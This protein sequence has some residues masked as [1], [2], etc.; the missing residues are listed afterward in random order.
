M[1]P[2]Y[3]NPRAQSNVPTAKLPRKINVSRRTI[4]TPETN[5]GFAVGPEAGMVRLSVAGGAV[6]VDITRGHPLFP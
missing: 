5:P 6:R 3:I 1:T 2:R 4:N